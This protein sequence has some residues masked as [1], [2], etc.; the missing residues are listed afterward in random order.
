LGEVRKLSDI[1]CIAVRIIAEE[2]ITDTTTIDFNE[3]FGDE[4]YFCE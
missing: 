4:E 2:A 1:R 3:K